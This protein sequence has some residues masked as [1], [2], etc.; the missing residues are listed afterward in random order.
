MVTDLAVESMERVRRLG[1]RD[2]MFGLIVSSDS[3]N[4]ENDFQVRNSMC[5][6]SGADSLVNQFAQRGPFT[7]N[8]V[9][10][11]ITRFEGGFPRTVMDND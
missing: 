10:D 5:L 3:K 11:E 6:N 9:N 8:E 2:V 7:T 4:S 1:N